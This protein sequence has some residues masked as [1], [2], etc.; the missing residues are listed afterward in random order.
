MQI[1]DII[2]YIQDGQR[3]FHDTI[4]DDLNMIKGGA[5]LLS[6]FSLMLVGFLYGAF[7]AVGPGHGKVI[8]SSYMLANEN[9][10]KRGLVIVLLSSLMQAV[11]AITLV[12]S[13]FYILNLARA[14]AEHITAILE[15]VSY[16]ILSLLGI[17]LII[18]GVR[19][20]LKPS[21]QQHHHD[22]HHHDEH[23]DHH[24]H[25]HGE[26]CGHA[27]GPDAAALAKK[28]DLPAIITMIVSIGIRPCTGAVLL[29]FLACIMGVVWPGIFAIFAMALG[30]ALTTSILAIITVK[31]KNAALGFIT[32]SEPKM[33]LAHG[34][35]S[36]TGGLIVIGMCASFM[37]VAVNTIGPAPDE[38]KKALPLMHLPNQ[39]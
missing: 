23:H 4:V 18:R 27:H 25:A 38:T 11:V 26:C 12:I 30:T 33:R 37:T 17:G 24:H 2:Q 29:L 28:Q 31:S 8:V 14:E 22:H 35:L 3:I 21:K 1:S 6:S 7:H 13:F 20:L 10:L 19:E 5:S 34:L 15:I 39:R 9:S 32:S 36:I 16:G